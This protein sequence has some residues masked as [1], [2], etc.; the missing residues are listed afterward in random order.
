MPR[1]R[2]GEELLA[3]RRAAGLG[4]DVVAE[5]L[6]CAEAKVRRI[7]QGR[8]SVGKLELAALLDLYGASPAQRST[9]AELQQLGKQRGWWSKH[10]KHIPARF[11]TLLGLESAATTIRGWEP[12]LVPGLLQ[13]ENYF[14]A[15][16]EMFDWS[17]EV[18]AAELEIRRSRQA[19]VWA[20]EPPTAWFV[21]DEAVLRRTIGGAEVMRAQLRHL[22]DL[23]DRCSI[24]VLPFAHGAHHGMSGALT[25]FEYDDD[26]HSPVAYVESNA[27]N[28]YLEEDDLVRCSLIMEHLRSD[29]LSPAASR[30]MVSDAI[31]QL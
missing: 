20:D 25:I 24:Q 16:L 27:G 5:H 14:R 22:L 15:V 10:G 30:R 17:D 8:V 28:I 6:G 12:I 7:E 1:W 3:L 19:H 18:K 31:D 4:A 23:M 13:T 2:L 29:A 21:V 9:L 26:V 11:G